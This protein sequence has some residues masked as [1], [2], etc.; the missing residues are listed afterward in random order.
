MQDL[1][2]SLRDKLDATFKEARSR[3]ELSDIEN[4][5]KIA[6]SAWEMLPEPKF[7][8]DVSKS[9]VQTLAGI[10]RDSGNFQEAISLLNELFSSGTLQPHQDRPRLVLGTVYFEMGDLANARKWFDEAN[11]I[12]KGRCFNG[13]PKKYKDLLAAKT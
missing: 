13:Q 8:W 12:S 2:I 6:E 3:L 4:A 10:Y 9:Y 5:V 7:E 11:R 1:D